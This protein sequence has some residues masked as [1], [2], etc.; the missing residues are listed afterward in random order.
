MFQIGD[1]LLGVVLV[2]QQ[3][4]PPRRYPG[5]KLEDATCTQAVSPVAEAFFSQSVPTSPEDLV[6]C[7]GG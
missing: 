7:A 4:V 2:H 6:G 1:A 3:I 5:T